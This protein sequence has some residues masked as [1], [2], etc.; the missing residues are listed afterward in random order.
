MA[1]L[2]KYANP[3]ADEAQGAFDGTDSFVEAL[4]VSITDDGSTAIVAMIEEL[5]RRAGRFPAN[6]VVQSTAACLMNAFLFAIMQML[7]DARLGR[8]PISH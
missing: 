8:Q 2:P 5:D 7:I 4:T 1:R 6:A 3:S